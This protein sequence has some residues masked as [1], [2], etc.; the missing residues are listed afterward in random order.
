MKGELSCI[1]N[2]Q[3]YEGG[4]GH[5][6]KVIWVLNLE[7]GRIST[8]LQYRYN[9]LTQIQF[10]FWWLGGWGKSTNGHRVVNDVRLGQ[11]PL[12]YR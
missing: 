5:H 3:Y 12:F 8:C 7:S 2:I 9:P 4:T 6:K 11:N 10:I 1:E